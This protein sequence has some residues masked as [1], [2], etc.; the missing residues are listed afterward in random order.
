MTTWSVKP[1]WKKS[2]LER[3]YLTKDGNRLMVETGW[4]WGEFTVET[5]DDN[6]PD[7]EAGVDIYDCGYES[8]LVET[9][10]GCWEE[11]D[12]DDCDEETTAWVE[13]FF[14]EGNSWLDLEE[15]GWSQDECEMIID[16]ELLITRLND[17]GTEGE[18]INTGG[19]EESTEPMTL[20]SSAAWPFSNSSE[21]TESAQFKC[22]ACDYTTEDINDLIEN[23]N[24]DDKGAFLCPKCS[25]KVD[26]S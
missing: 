23:T 4:R 25:S 8:E 14:E 19:Q 10:D 26:L 5:E 11:V 3:N 13:E 20:A 1:T 24:D 12:T 18:T 17:D 22:T 9:N 15:N 16:C 6:P 2:I 21:V 7:I